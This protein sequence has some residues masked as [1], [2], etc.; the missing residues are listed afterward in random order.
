MYY[1]FKAEN[2]RQANQR[3]EIAGYA[4]MI[5]KDYNLRGYQY[6][7]TEIFSDL[8]MNKVIVGLYNEIDGA[9]SYRVHTVCYLIGNKFVA[10]N[11]T[12]SERKFLH[13]R[14]LYQNDEFR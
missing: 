2:I 4:A 11:Y 6:P 9:G 8:L 12:R 3:I 13:D 1:Y 14:G 10:A 5:G 7:E